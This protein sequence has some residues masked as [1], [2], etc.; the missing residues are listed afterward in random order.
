MPPLPPERKFA[1]QRESKKINYDYYRGE[2][3]GNE[4]MIY[5]KKRKKSRVLCANNN[6]YNLLTGVITIHPG[7]YY[8]CS[9]VFEK[10]K[11]N[12]FI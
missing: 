10:E 9:S 8:F 1:T 11:R 5:L 12:N 6:N 7:N 3:E 2:I 4:T